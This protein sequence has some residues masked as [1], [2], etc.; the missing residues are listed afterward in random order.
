MSPDTTII[1]RLYAVI[2]PMMTKDGIEDTPI[3]RHGYLIGIRKAE[4]ESREM[5]FDRYLI[6]EA[7]TDEIIRLG[8]E[9]GLD[10][11][12]KSKS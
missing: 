9:L 4:S 10:E 7:L 11:E 1:E 2:L 6:I 3:N 5:N 12:G 8:N